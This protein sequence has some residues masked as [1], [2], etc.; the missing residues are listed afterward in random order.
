MAK[1]DDKKDGKAVVIDENNVLES[2]KEKNKMPENLAEEV[3]KEIEQDEKENKMRTLKRAILCAEYKNKKAL[4]ALRARRREEKITKDGLTKSKELLD[5]LCGGKITP[6]EYD[7]GRKEWYKESTKRKEESDK[8]YRE[9][10]E[11]LQS[12]YPGYY[13]YE[14]DRY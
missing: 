4:L 9:E 14:W 6:I 1:K 3:R 12:A 2:L 10:I 7:N 8:Q 5:A 13:S 11:E